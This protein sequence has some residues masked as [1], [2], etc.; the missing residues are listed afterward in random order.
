MTATDNNVNIRPDDRLQ[1]KVV[2]IAGSGRRVS[3][4]VALVLASKGPNPGT[5]QLEPASAHLPVRNMA[6]DRS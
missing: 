6:D 3:R 1:G 4:A 2:L 5:N